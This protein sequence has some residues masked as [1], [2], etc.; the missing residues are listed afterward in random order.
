MSEFS[1]PLCFVGH[2]HVAAVARTSTDSSRVR[3]SRTTEGQLLDVAYDRWII[4]PGS[5]GQPRDGDPRAAY[6]VYD[7]DQATVLVRRVPYPVEE[8]QTRITAAGLPDVL[9]ARLALGR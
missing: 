2:T 3:F 6:V 5:V 7:T 4:N 8:T 1:T 9:G